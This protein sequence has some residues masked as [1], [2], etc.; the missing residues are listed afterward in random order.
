MDGRDSDGIGWRMGWDGMGSRWDRM[1][2][3]GAGNIT[4]PSL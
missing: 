4:V 1:E 3:D 2:A